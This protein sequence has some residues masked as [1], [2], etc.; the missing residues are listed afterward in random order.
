[1]QGM[2]A[3]PELDGANPVP[4]FRYGRG[5][6][7]GGSETATVFAYMIEAAL[8]PVVRSWQEKGE[9]FQVDGRPLCTHWIWADNTYHRQI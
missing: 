5:G 2:N 9:G 4:A 8:S 7:Q 3:E 6:H 1:M